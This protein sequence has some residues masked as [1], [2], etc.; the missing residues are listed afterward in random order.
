MT[1]EDGPSMNHASELCPGRNNVLDVIG[2]LYPLG[3][4]CHLDMPSIIVCGDRSIG[5]S[6]IL[7]AI[8]GIPCPMNESQCS[9]L[10]F[11]LALRR[12]ETVSM[13]AEILPGSCRSGA[14]RRALRAFCQYAND[15]DIGSTLKEA[16]EVIRLHMTGRLFCGDILRIEVAGPAQPHLT[17]IDMPG[18]FPTESDDQFEQ[19]A[20]CVEDT[21]LE[22]MKCQK[23]TII[24][25]VSAE[26]DFALQR[27]I[28]N[29]R[30]FDP[31][32]A[33]TLG[34]IIKPGTPDVGSDNERF[35]AELAQNNYVY[36]Q[37]GWLVLCSRFHGTVAS[38][39]WVEADF[40]TRGVWRSLDPSRYGIKALRT[41]VDGIL[42][43]EIVDK[44]PV[45]LKEAEA[46]R[47]DYEQRLL[48]LGPSRDTVEQKRQFLIRVST[49]FSS[50]LKAAVDGSYTGAF[51]SLSEASGY[52]RR[53][54]TVIRNALSDFAVRM[55]EEGQAQIIQDIEPA[56]A[57][58]PR[59][60]SRAQHMDEVKALMG[61]YG[62]YELP[63][64]YNPLIVSDIFRKQCRPWG[65]IIGKVRRTVMDSVE[66]VV[67]EA[68]HYV[69][70]DVTAAGISR[71]II[72]PYLQELGEALR[73]K[74][75]ELLEPHLLGHPI[76][77]NSLLTETVREAQNARNWDNMEMHLKTF[78]GDLL[79][80]S[81]RG[82]MFDMNA[83][84]DSLVTERELDLDAYPY[85]LAIDTADAYYKIALEKII[86]DVSVLAIER[87][88]IQKLPNLLAA[89]IICHLTNSEV[90]SI[91]SESDATLTERALITEKLTMFKE[92]LTE[93]GRFKKQLALFKSL[94][95]IPS[96]NFTESTSLKH[97]T[98]TSDRMKSSDGAEKLKEADPWGVDDEFWESIGYP[99]KGKKPTPKKKGKQ[100]IFKKEEDVVCEDGK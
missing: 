71:V 47:K 83:L 1:K 81:N 46:V 97:L 73:S 66:T 50:L 78:F 35:Y 39:G 96:K 89:E 30:T 98:P 59:R 80:E 58:D 43:D 85:T 4:A 22:Y 10:V 36:L 65:D 17:L 29:A 100:P 49:T 90:H 19:D 67:N 64:T 15:L 99:F 21:M 8:T 41:C 60:I 92:G 77:Y 38:H 34:V 87:C 69:T 3:L 95:E 62:G 16:E 68:L 9:P 13:S 25:V 84:L 93:L 2:R 23:A 14:E 57:D 6:A 75:D 11:E 5:K 72:G 88:L 52:S 40:I 86:D 63:G 28:A 45:I 55:R 54:R 82:I 51:F 91:A 12:N 42:Y 31:Q 70:D 20:K 53:L 7:S 61:Q 76:T 94:D 26:K 79:D 56:S 44:L 24:A 74:V 18:L 27:V 33:R 37:L 48:Q 32:G